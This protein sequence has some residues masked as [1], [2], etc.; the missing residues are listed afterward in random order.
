MRLFVKVVSHVSNKYGFWKEKDETKPQQPEGDR[1]KAVIV[2][3]A[4][5]LG[6]ISA[7]DGAHG[8]SGC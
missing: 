7:N 5:I 3:P 2:P 6:N 1:R 4:E 8:G